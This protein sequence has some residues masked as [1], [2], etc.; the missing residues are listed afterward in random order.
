MGTFGDLSLNVN[1]DDVSG[2]CSITHITLQILAKSYEITGQT[3]NQF[4]IK[5]T[6]NLGGYKKYNSALTLR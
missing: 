6:P 2:C 1:C 3:L 4:I 5:L